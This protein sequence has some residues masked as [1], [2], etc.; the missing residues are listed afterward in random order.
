MARQKETNIDLKLNVNF[1]S[2]PYTYHRQLLPL[3]A[4]QHTTHLQ[5]AA[6]LPGTC[7]C[8][9]TPEEYLC[10]AGLLEITY[11]R[12]CA[13]SK[14]ALTRFY[15]CAET[16]P[17]MFPAACLPFH[18]PTNNNLMR[19]AQSVCS[20]ATWRNFCRGKK[21]SET[22]NQDCCVSDPAQVQIGMVKCDG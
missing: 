4:P 21:E 2:R 13:V 17:L 19:F 22:I 16:E 14:C 11:I 18:N 3:T 7:A 1:A 10:I 20:S 6:L 5:R 9:S 12:W 8:I 15:G